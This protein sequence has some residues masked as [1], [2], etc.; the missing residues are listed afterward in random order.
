[1]F[2]ITWKIFTYLLEFY[3]AGVVFV[4]LLCRMFLRSG[5]LLR[6]LANVSVHTCLRFQTAV[7]S[8]SGACS[9]SV[10][11]L[12][13]R[14]MF[15]AHEMVLNQMRHDVLL[16]DAYK[17]RVVDKTRPCKEILKGKQGILG[18]SGPAARQQL[19]EL[20]QQELIDFVEQLAH[21]A[22]SQEKLDTNLMQIVEDECCFQAKNMDTVEMLLVADAFFM[23][24]YSY[25]CSRYYS[26]MFRE[27]EHRWMHMTIQKEDVVQLAVCIVTYR[28]FPLLLVRNIEQFVCSHM[29]KFSA[30]ELSIMCSAFFMT[31]TSLRSVE[32]MDKLTDAVLSSI[33]SGELK[34]YQLGSILKA[35]RHAH[36]AKIS[37]WEN[38]G[39]LL[40]SLPAFQNEFMLTDLSNVAFAY[41]SLKIS[42]STLFAGLSSHAVKLIENQTAM[43][44][45]DVGRLVWS[46]ALLQEPLD[47]VVQNH[48]LFIL[49]RDV[50]LMEQFS[51]A[52][53]ESLLGLAMQKIYPVDLLQRL[54]S[55]KLLM[56]KHGMVDTMLS[57]T[58]LFSMFVFYFYCSVLPS[59][60]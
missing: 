24:R 8:V 45:K 18:Q 52:F 43:R 11:N 29:D 31:N 33:P 13:H 51:E 16:Q 7:I 58:V 17:H 59:A 20:T 26:A 57:C 50:Y 38:L 10:K 25:L 19:K 46:F 40:S 44:L 34:A 54:F 39:N 27:F 5:T 47:E 9:E 4:C 23:M 22:M 28:K 12:Q 21:M 41:A 15:P 48:L 6:S 35:L 56:Q 49:R 53:V 36:F 3:V 30:C 1:M 37:F 32:L 42:H 2:H 55:T 60:F 14:D